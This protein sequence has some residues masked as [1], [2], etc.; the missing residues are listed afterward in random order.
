MFLLSEG[1]QNYGGIMAGLLKN[2]FSLCTFTTALLFLTHHVDGFAHNAESQ[3]I[4]GKRP[5]SCGQNSAFYQ[6]DDGEEH[7]IDNKVY[8]LTDQ[9]ARGVHGAIEA[10]KEHTSLRGKNITVKGIM[11][12]KNNSDKKFWK[13]GVKASE[14]AGV[15]LADSTL[16][17]VL[18]GVESQGGSIA[19]S[20]GS[21]DA[22]EVGALA[23]GKFQSL[24]RLTNTQVSF[25]GIGV[26]AGEKGVLILEGVSM[27]GKGG[28]SKGGQGLNVDHQGDNAAFHIS[29]NGY[30]QFVKGFVDV[31]DAHGLLLLGDKGPQI[32]IGDSNVTVKGNAVYGMHFEGQPA[33]EERQLE[34]RL[35]R[36]D[37]KKTR[38]VV[39]ESIAL[40]SSKFGK[41]DISLK[42]TK[43][44]G[45]LLL[46]AESGSSIKV[47]ADASALVGQT[48]IDNSSTVN[49]I[50]KNNSQW[51]LLRPRHQNLRNPHYRD[52]S[53][54]SSV[55]LVN[56]SITFE[57]PKPST[58]HTYQT[59]YI[60]KGSGVVYQASG[61]AW[62]HL[63]ARLN[64]HDTSDHQ[65]T[66]RLL[67]H[68]DVKGKTIVHIHGVAGG[69]GE[70][71]EKAH[72]VSIIQ[73]YGDASFDSF[74]L[75]G[76]YVALDGAPY[77]YVLRSYGPKA[78]GGEEH[79][80]QRFAQNGGAFWN[81]RLENEYVQTSADY[82]GTPMVSK[83]TPPVHAS[84]EDIIPASSADVVPASS[85]D[86][87]SVSSVS[88]ADVVPASSED[89]L[90]KIET[91]SLSGRGVR[92]VVPQ[93]PTY[94]L[95]PNS[96]FHAGLM[97]ISNQN[98]QLEI[99]RAH[100]REML[101]I[102]ENPT[103]FLR[104][105][106]GSSRYTSDLSALEYGYGG[107]LGYYALEAGV[108]LQKIENVDSALSFGVM[109]SYGK[110]S[111]QPLN[112]EQ[113]QKS[114]F[115]KWTAT[116]YGSLQHDTGFYVDGLL[117]YGFF[118]GDVL[119][120]VRGKTA[121]LK[122]NPLSVSLMSGRKVATGY[123]GV[124]FDPQAQVVY[125]YL[126]FNEARDIDHF[127]I[128]MD[129]LDQWV[130]RVG[131]RLMKT[132]AAPEKDRDVSFYGKI[133][134]AHDFGKERSVRFKDSFQLGAFGSSLE[135][136]LG[137]NARL[138]QNLAFHG[139]LV[140]QHK[141]SKGGFSGISF[142]GGLRYR[143]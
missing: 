37:L 116:V 105:Y 17:G 41:S 22:I 42:D 38:F 67:I 127:N 69:L 1:G 88:S 117:S 62:I 11:D 111:L 136:G 32:D 134:F 61:D 53:F 96:L 9:N 110:L 90:S 65:V 102:R 4:S 129:K 130:V 18:V 84:V 123:E 125:Q 142:S 92:S 19:I 6:C 137:L 76:Q 126:Q 135:A 141:L 109:G 13:Y 24:V 2:R 34:G 83:Q 28:P 47:T 139:D 68:G 115:D 63:N 58:A 29:E 12:E 73:V 133:H 5:S 27:S 72:S 50:L 10:S 35:S 124:V 45:D 39:P 77:K 14:K 118:K 103:S 108:L 8:S 143:F 81:F 82:R 54:I 99:Q 70:K 16:S 66:D 71:N 97:D 86:S 30:A 131:G 43:L 74:Q 106:G 78:T 20:G 113:S 15:S 26:Q 94:L 60:G 114:T 107:D 80:K 31:S 64:P 101:E 3:V 51:V 87:V 23:E 40:Y 52:V 100:P 36:V 121:T 59:L 85:E 132:L 119:T 75:N 21:I 44:F 79:V 140:Y 55:H 138:S 46:K 56:S 48:Q 112:V 95:L 33:L 128:E 49:L 98:K 57:K 104:G 122:G 91:V 93:V 25:G 120:T 89:S 7:A